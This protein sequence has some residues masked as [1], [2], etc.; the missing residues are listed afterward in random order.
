VGYVRRTEDAVPRDLALPCVVLLD[1]IGELASLFPL[2]DVV[3][4]G[5]TLARRGGH[6]ILEPAAVKR[7][8][9]TGP[10]LENFAA[11]AAEFREQR[12]FLEIEEPGKLAAAVALLLDHP[13]LREEMGVRAANLAAAK[14]GA[15]RKAVDEI[16]RQ[17][18]LAV[19]CW[20][21]L[22][23][24]RY[25]L[26]PLAKTWALVSARQQRRKKVGAQRLNTPVISIGGISMG[27]AG[28]TPLVDHLTG[29]LSQRGHHPAILTRGYRRQSIET[30]ILIG[31]GD[32]APVRVTGDEAQIFVQSGY[33]DLGIGA[34]RLRTGHLLEERYQPDVFLLD[35]GFQHAR[36]ERDLDLVVIDALNP[37]AGGAVFP[38]GALRE[39]MSAL[40]RAGV[41]VI[42]R[43][44]PGREYEGIR[45]QLRTWNQAPIFKA[46]VQPRGWV[47]YVTRKPEQPAEGPVAAFCGLA[48]PASFWGTLRSLGVPPVFHWAFDDHHHYSCE[49]LQRLAAQAHMH[50]SSVLLTTEKDAMNLPDSAPGVLER[51]GVNLY[52]L[53]IGVQVENENQLLEL[54]ESRMRSAS[55]LKRIDR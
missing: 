42:M 39:P 51:A 32:P 2:A 4:M 44:V 41:F 33:A 3:F 15:T 22:S 25:I 1:T 20:S 12:G 37:F 19:P 53:K 45:R 48:N 49:E 55:G 26:W 5:G 10:H 27:G 43:A 30:T 50:G 40:E 23:P 46:R 35:D 31:A 34:D 24:A 13:E 38:L 6:N 54:I 9:V 17:H 47:N 16:L 36:L 21:R 8:I 52:W 7:A 11:I 14:R 28:K 18:D 29:R